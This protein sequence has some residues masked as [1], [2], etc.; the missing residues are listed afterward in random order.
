MRSHT[1]HLSEE[2]I[3]LDIEGGLASREAGR[4]REHLSACWEC[5]ARKQE[6]ESAIGDFVRYHAGR[7]ENDEL[8]SPTGPRA[9]LKARIE[10]IS[11]S[12]PRHGNWGSRWGAAAATVA[13]VAL[14]LLLYRGTRPGTQTIVTVPNS[15][16]TPG[17]TVRVT[18]RDLCRSDNGKNKAVPVALQRRVFAE[19]GIAS[20]EPR[21]YEVDYL[22][23][24][25]L[26]GADDVRNLWPQSSSSTEWN[27]RVKDDLEDRLR[28]MVCDGS[29]DLEV[30]QQ[31][32]AGDW[33]EAYKKYFHTEA[34]TR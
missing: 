29:L 6:M 32:I 1:S 16:L 5:R 20:P 12:E 15:T 19:Y 23:T 18:R 10:K 26:G 8:P 25:A 21:A 4:V 13:V 28:Q 22:I 7:S 2:Q 30:A 31:E 3:L 14:G 34:P 11:A 27:A 33:I 9:L 17:A 24:P